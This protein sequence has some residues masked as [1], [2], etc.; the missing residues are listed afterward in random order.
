[1][2]AWEDELDALGSEAS[3]VDLR[4]LLDCVPSQKGDLVQFVRRTYKARL[5]EAMAEWEDHLDALGPS[6]DTESLERMLQTVPDATSPL[7]QYVCG[8]L[9]GRSS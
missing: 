9:A 6:A 8:V 3:I 2:D 1:M 4:R 7:A 5:V